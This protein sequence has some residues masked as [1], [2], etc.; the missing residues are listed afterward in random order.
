MKIVVIGGTGLIG[1]KTVAILRQ[2]GHA[3]IAASRMDVAFMPDRLSL[4]RRVASVSSSSSP[5]KAFS[6]ASE[7]VA[8]ATL[9]RAPAVRFA[10][11]RPW[12]A[13]FY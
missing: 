6:I 8:G 1:S 13:M 2:R 11:V 4:L 10:P 12:L 7:S 9:E 3:V 5:P